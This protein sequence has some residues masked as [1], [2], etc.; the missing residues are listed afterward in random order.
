MVEF[1]FALLGCVVATLSLI[2]LCLLLCGVGVMAACGR[3]PAWGF[4]SFFE[5]DYWPFTCLFA[6]LV[7]NVGC[8]KFGYS[9]VG[10]AFLRY[11][12]VCSCYNTLLHCGFC[13]HYYFE[14]FRFGLRVFC[15]MLT[16]FDG[17]VCDT[18][19]DKLFG[20]GW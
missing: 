13:M 10:I 17:C 6:Y 16:L 18:V 9:I 2:S 19:G 7:G 12:W 1:G 14:L 3:W 4:D 11:C 8:L 15:S 5:F 20:I